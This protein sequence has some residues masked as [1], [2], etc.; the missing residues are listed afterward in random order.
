M[1]KSFYDEIAANKRGSF[2]L[3]VSFS[4]IIIVLVGVITWLWFGSWVVGLVLGA[5]IAV[6]S[7]LG[8]YYGGA[9]NILRMSHAK[10]VTKQQDPFLINTVE[11]LAIAAGN[12]KPKVYI[13]EEES[14]NAF[15]TGRDPQHASITITSGA[16]KK[17]NR[18]ELEGV[19]A[20][21]MS[22]IH[23]YDIRFMMLV[24]VLVGVIVL[25]SQFILR[26]FLW[27]GAGR[28]RK[29]SG[30]GGIVIIVLIVFALVLALLSP[31]I[32]QMIKF[33]ISR[34]R[35]FLADATGA[36]M[37]R[38]PQGLA[39]ALKKIRDDNDTVVDTANRAT[40]HL[41]LEDPLRKK[42]KVNWL[43]RMFMTHPPINERIKKLEG[44]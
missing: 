17:L 10:E 37:T 29:S 26:S 36:K 25:I 30:N 35:E 7:V 33:S 27:G 41:Y 44:M 31:L 14:I 20:H 38:Y 15:A 42:K 28:S 32:A 16:R 24:A 19:I 9:G 18:Q 12:P 43:D 22:H 4:F 23:N 21:E 8:G 34:K 11:G 2:W 1:K 40:A 6:I 3:M 13:I 5:I 39:N